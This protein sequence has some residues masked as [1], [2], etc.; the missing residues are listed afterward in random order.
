M[1]EP[2][3][4]DP[5]ELAG[6]L[7]EKGRA[8]MTVSMRVMSAGKGYQYLLKSVASG[9]GNRSLNAPDEVLHRGR[10]AARAMAG[11]RT[12]RRR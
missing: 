12:P 7:C 3:E 5:V 11:V 2:A 10:D 8:A 1:D 6:H 9:D 4:P